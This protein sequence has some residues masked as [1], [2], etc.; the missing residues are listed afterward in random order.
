MGQ[1]VFGGKSSKNIESRLRVDVCAT[2]MA[3]AMGGES[4]TPA[5]GRQRPV[6]EMNGVPH[7]IDEYCLA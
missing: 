1:P 4:F 6:F 7:E 3:M 5:R 2:A